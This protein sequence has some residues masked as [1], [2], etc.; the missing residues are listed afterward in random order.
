LAQRRLFVGLKVVCGKQHFVQGWKYKLHRHYL[1]LG[2]KG[3]EY[4]L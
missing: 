1:L 3:A 2:R 4:L